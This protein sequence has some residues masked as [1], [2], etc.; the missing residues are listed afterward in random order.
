MVD[1]NNP[2]L[3]DQPT[4]K[5]LFENANKILSN[6]MPT[7]Q[8]RESNQLHAAI[9]VKSHGTITFADNKSNRAEF[10]RIPPDASVARVK[11]FL[12]RQWCSERPSLVISVTGGAKD[13][14]MKPK[15]LRAF[16]RGLSKVTR[17]T[18]A[19]IIT[20]GMNTGIMKLVGEIV[21]IN[22]DRSRPIHLIG[23]ATWGCVSGFEQLDVHGANVH[24]AKSRSEQK[25]EAPLEPNH[26]EF[27]FVDDGSERKYGRE[28]QFRARLE[29][30][31]SGGFFATRPA[32]SSNSTYP[33]LTKTQ[34]LRP[35]QLD[36]VPVVL[37]VVEGGPNTVRTVHEAVVQNNIPA[38]FFEGTGR[39]CDLFAKAFRL[40]NEYRQKL[41]LTDDTSHLDPSTVLR[42]YDELKSKLREE[43]KHELRGISGANDSAHAH[44]TKAP[45]L[46]T[47]TTTKDHRPA[48]VDTTDY[49]ELVYECID[50][51]TNFLN[52][53]SLTSRSPV[54]PDI[55]LAILQ[56]LLN[57][58]SAHDSSKTNNQR[59]REQFHLALEWNRVDIAKNYIMNNER[60]WEKIN[61]NDMFELALSRN[62][63]EFVKLFLDHDFS[64]TDV[65]RNNGKL[66]LLYMNTMEEHY[67]TSTSVDSLQTIYEEII[68]PLIG[69]F[70]EVEAV[71]HPKRHVSLSRANSQNEKEACS[72]F[73]AP[74]SDRAVYVE[75]IVDN[76]EAS[77]SSSSSSGIHMDIDRELFLW[78]VITGRRE[79]NL[80]F[81]AR[82][83]NK[84][85][86][87]L[88]ATLIYRK[89]ARK[90]NDTSYHQTADEFESLAVQ[91][92]DRFYQTNTRACTKAIIRK[93]P[94]YGNVTWLELAITAEAKQFIA[95][96]AVQDVLNNIWFGY[97]DQ[98]ETHN[99]IIFSSIMI[100][101]SGTLRYHD[102]LVKTNEQTSYLNDT[103]RKTNLLQKHQTK[104][105][106]PLTERTSDSINMRLMHG[107][108]EIDD[109][110]V[111]FVDVG[112]YEKTRTHI[113]RYF[114]NILRF[115]RA[116]IVKYLYSLYFHVAFLLLFSYVILCDFYPLY[117]FKSDICAP[118]N[119]LERLK[120]MNVNEST[121]NQQ[122][123]SSE[124]QKRN[125]P[126]VTEIILA[127]WIFTL[128]CEEI[129]QFF[130]LEARTIRNAITAYFEVFWNRLDMLAIVLFFIGF[131][132]RFIPTTECFCAAR[133]VL[134]VDLTLWFIRSLDFFA[135]VKRLGPKLV[136][137]GE[138]AHD[139][140]FF[141]L[142][143]TVFI[144]GFGVSSYSLIYGAQE[145]TWHLPRDIINLAYW[146]IFGELNALDTFE[147]NYSPNGYAV[148]ILLVIYMAIVS[149]LLVN[150]LIAMFSNTFDRLQNDTDRIWKFQRYSLICEYLSR[151]S[152]PP[153]FI[154]FCHL[155]RFI[156][157]AVSPC[158]K[159]S[160][161]KATYAQHTNRTKYKVLLDEKSASNIE[162]AEDALGDEV[163]YNYSKVG[164]KLVDDND[165]DEERIQSPQ[166]NIVNKLRVLENRTHLLTTQ[167]AQMFEYLECL[168]E[169]LR[170]LGG[171][172]I[173]MPE[174]RRFDFD[175]SFDELTTASD[176][177][178][179]YF[180][181]DSVI[182]D[183]RRQST[184][185]PEEV[186]TPIINFFSSRRK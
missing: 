177:A 13:Y 94:A 118:A 97:I 7:H 162:I 163:Y 12:N 38:V 142:M 140:K 165:L 145:F 95:Q 39:C 77:T 55:D 157:Y 153:P 128:L 160:W 168:M 184:A 105:G 2:N 18:G 107:V 1:S 111:T 181:R 93:I 149:I 10:I 58:T 147:H 152:L 169:G 61:L 161:L 138:M 89:R 117:E 69:D 67:F 79:F 26:T 20:G 106:K 122:S 30:A 112:S 81:W 64:L 125:R 19:W 164:R 178:R 6:F 31:I 127:G 51:R 113:L 68:Q 4:Q 87:A 155:W 9:G 23:I 150:L 124:L 180:R 66:P 73:T 40:Y 173:R 182:D 74:R 156:L 65:F 135:A 170:S 27:I 52:I 5:F 83:K 130:S 80:L 114:G 158:L 102:E 32:T 159:S 36:P 172:R 104:H 185:S 50:T 121:T 98:R 59:K 22:P 24:Y 34:S 8:R 175:D 72:C 166:E 134:S 183:V 41:E 56:A 171:E 60:D 154:I 14:H 137:I 151:P 44:T 123:V 21:Q 48:A 133:I 43:L 35:E 126:S 53:V 91:I 144:L 71:L 136:M 116:P 174:R 108:N 54:E 103:S 88:I 42:R 45:R 11:E 37:L 141:M 28:I 119:Q 16:R 76:P 179:R 115:I 63:T 176:Q 100:W 110:P 143:L 47:A 146:Q 120:N 139:L 57:A 29:Q 70:F 99:S 129:R 46:S 49:F 92:L 86:A 17:T 85:C 78:S 186:Q 167:Q 62:Q 84:I 82:G 90:T 109:I 33:T 131:T 3:T 25:G 15:L 101:Y 132:L 148:F 75:P 96:R